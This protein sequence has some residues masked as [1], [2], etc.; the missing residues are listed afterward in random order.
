M[1]FRVYS[2]PAWQR[3][4]IEAG[5]ALPAEQPCS[6]TAVTGTQNMP[7]PVVCGGP[8]RA[9]WTTPA[10]GA[11]QLGFHPT[12][13]TRYQHGCP[14]RVMELSMMSSATRKK[15]CSCARAIKR[16]SGW[17][18]GNAAFAGIAR[19]QQYSPMR[20]SA[21]HVHRAA[22]MQKPPDQRQKLTRVASLR[23]QT[24]PF[25]APAQDVGLQR[26]FRL[27]LLQDRQNQVECS[28]VGF[29][30]IWLLE[31]RAVRK[32][33]P[34]FER[35]TDRLHLPDRPSALA[36]RPGRPCRG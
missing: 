7:L 34:E 20:T 23:A 28:A 1:S 14:R 29:P 18:W 19:T 30:G 24:H 3:H 36:A 16:S 32:R 31:Q 6:Y 15:A 9:A 4:A 27:H 2:G 25:Y 11:R 33:C 17:S 13:G 10:A 21:G 8:Q 35:S 26:L 12:L 22:A 5:P